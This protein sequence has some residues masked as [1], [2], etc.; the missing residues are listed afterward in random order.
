M[1]MSEDLIKQITDAVLAE[2]KQEMDAAPASGCRAF[3]GRTR[4]NQ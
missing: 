4:P 1:Q 2:I 3:Y